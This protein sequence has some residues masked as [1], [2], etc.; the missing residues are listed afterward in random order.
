MRDCGYILRYPKLKSLATT[1]KNSIEKMK[2]LLLF[3]AAAFVCL[4]MSAQ[5]EIKFEKKAHN[6]GTFKSTEVQ[7]VTIKFTNVGDKP[8]IIQRAQGSCGCTKPKFSTDPIAPG[9]SGELTISYNPQGRST[10]P[11][12]KFVT[13]MSNSKNPV[14]RI[15][16]EGV[17]EK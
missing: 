6:F 17:S 1:L 7:T 10:G 4:G 8:L 12:H 3:F 14:E 11:F 5:A 2:K 9:E 15:T 13:V 16:I